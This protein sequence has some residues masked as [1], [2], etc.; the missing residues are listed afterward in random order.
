MQA[1]VI[2]LSDESWL[3]EIVDERSSIEG[4]INITLSSRVLNQEFL[5][6]EDGVGRLKINYGADAPLSFGENEQV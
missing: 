5:Y 6:P 2:A 4:I 3:D 1:T